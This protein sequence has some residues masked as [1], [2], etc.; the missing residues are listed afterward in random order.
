MFTDE[1]SVRTGYV[2]ALQETIERRKGDSPKPARASYERD[3]TGVFADRTPRKCTG[4]VFGSFGDEAPGVATCAVDLSDLLPRGAVRVG[5][6]TFAAC[7]PLRG[8]GKTALRTSRGTVGD[9]L[10]TLGA[11][12]EHGEV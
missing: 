10:R 2:F 11:V 6:F 5:G 7:F 12:D 1:N 3:A 8:N 9:S 4:P